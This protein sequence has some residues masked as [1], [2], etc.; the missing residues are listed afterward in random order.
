MAQQYPASLKVNVK[1]GMLCFI[2]FMLF[3]LQDRLARFN[4]TWHNKPSEKKYAEV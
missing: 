1:F 2:F 4:L 3:S